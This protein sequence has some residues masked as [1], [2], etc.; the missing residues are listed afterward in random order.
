[1]NLESDIHDF[2]GKA[3]YIIFFDKEF[4]SWKWRIQTLYESVR[5]IKECQLSYKFFTY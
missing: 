3:S 2:V 1:M 5:N 4:E